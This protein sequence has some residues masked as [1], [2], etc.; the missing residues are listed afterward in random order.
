[1]SDLRKQLDAL[2]SEYRSARYP[3]K[4]SEELLASSEHKWSRWRIG[5]WVTIATGIA[6]AILISLLNTKPIVQPPPGQPTVVAMTPTT[7][8]TDDGFV[9]VAELSTES[10]PDDVPLVPSG[11]SLVPTAEAMDFG[12]MPS[13]PTL[14]LPPLSAIEESS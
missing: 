4:L 9:H 7:Q 8:P 6:A 3:G 1:M 2:K 12:M 5:G 10:F 11:E 13:F 14:D